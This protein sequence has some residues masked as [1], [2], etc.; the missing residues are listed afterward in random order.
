MVSEFSSALFLDALDKKLADIEAASTIPGLTES[1]DALNA[2]AVLHVFDPMELSD[3][4]GMSLGSASSDLLRESYQSIGFRHK[5]YRSLRERTRLDVLSRIGGAKK[6]LDYVQANVGRN[7][8]AEQRMFEELLQGSYGDLRDK[9]RTELN[10]LRNVTAWAHAVGVANLPDETEVSRALDYTT[11]V[12]PIEHLFVEA[13]VGRKAE[14]NALRAFVGITEPTFWRSITSVFSNSETHLMMLDGAGGV[15]KTALL[16][17]FLY[18]HRADEKGPLFPFAYLACDDHRVSIDAPEGILWD[19]A[20]QLERIARVA[21]TNPNSNLA[22][23]VGEAI[24]QFQKQS[25]LFADQMR[26]L[27]GRRQ[28]YVEQSGRINAAR[29]A[30]RNLAYAFAKVVDATSVALHRGA[31]KRTANTDHS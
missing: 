15:G 28:D 19:A 23:A 24:R 18:Q 3:R 25:S 17:H 27:G 12:E 29:D 10:A 9:T 13:F 21:G 14:M 22:D 31:W 16:G 26:R 4:D 20:Q 8:T 6:A 5:G 11:A 30:E 1:S 2:A 7:L